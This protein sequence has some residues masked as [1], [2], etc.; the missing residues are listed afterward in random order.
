[1]SICANLR[2]KWDDWGPYDYHRD[3]NLTYPM[4]LEGMVSWGPSKAKLYDQDT[5][6]GVLGR[7]RTLNEYSNRYESTMLENDLNEW[8]VRIFL[9]VVGNGF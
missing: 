5:R 6:V 7:Y 4:Q 3:F 9:E 1:M 2:A 8:E